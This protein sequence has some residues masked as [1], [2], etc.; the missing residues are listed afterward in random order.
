M[1]KQD[2]DI[3]VHI[4]H[5][6]MNAHKHCHRKYCKQPS[7]FTSSK[8]RQMF[9]KRQLCSPWKNSTPILSNLKAQGFTKHS[10]NYME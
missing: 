8:W 9:R 4:K 6:Y 2:F 7:Q 1:K 5:T 3:A 10:K